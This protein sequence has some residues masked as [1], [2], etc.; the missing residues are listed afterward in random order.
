[1]SGFCSMDA[2]NGA[3]V[4]WAKEKNID[5]DRRFNVYNPV[6]VSHLFRFKV[7]HF[8]DLVWC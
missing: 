1:M 5:L 4:A 3:E 7:S 6:K 2:R 8:D